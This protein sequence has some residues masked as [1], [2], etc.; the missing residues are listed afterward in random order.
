MAGVLS[1]GAQRIADRALS[2]STVKD[3]F[4]R[5]NCAAVNFGESAKI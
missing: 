2:I 1:D 4:R 3:D 5:I